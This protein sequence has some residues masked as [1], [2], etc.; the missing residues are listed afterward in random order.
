VR[1]LGI[2]TSCDETAAAVVDDGHDI[3]SNVV[4][5]Q[6][7]LHARYGGVVP[8]I[9]CRAHVESILPVIEDALEQARTRPADL[10]GIAVTRGPG[11][12][13]ALLVGISAAK[14]LAWV[15]DR[16][17]VGVHH[18]EAHMHAACMGDSRIEYPYVS[19]VVSGGHTALYVS[20][21]PRRHT[22][23]GS[24]TDDAAGEAFDKV[25]S[26]L[27][28]GY[29]GGPSVERAAR[30][31]DPAAVPFRRAL[32]GRGSLDFS[33]SGIKTAVLYHCKGQNAS[34]DERILPEVRIE[35]VAASFQEAVVDVLVARSFEAADREGIPRIAVVGGVA[36]NRRLRE[37]FAA[38]GAE[39][40]IAVTFPDFSLCT[41][42]AA[43]VAGVGYS[44]IR[45]GENDGFEFDADPRPIRA[46]YEAGAAGASG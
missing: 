11:L 38:T 23:I 27:G 31:G 37:R 34:R 35:D 5:S 6:A 43:M 41:D 44:R 29:P 45:D 10:D 7:D 30:D 13:G 40:G 16:P 19:L 18:I 17:L 3:L 21:A 39:R 33:F 28:L 8:E 4:A 14:S 22:L 42:N 32:P 12:I 20:R 46:P 25:A 9:A 26:I 24:T 2:E 1:V 15:W 36:A